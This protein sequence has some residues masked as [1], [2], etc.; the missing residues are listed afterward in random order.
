[1]KPIASILL[2]LAT[3]QICHAEEK[4]IRV[5]VALCDNA[6]QGIV[7]VPQRIGNG[8]QPDANLYWGCTEGLK[9][10]FRASRQWKLEK[11][12]IPRDQVVLERLEF[13]H[14]SGDATLVAE[15]YRGSNIRDCLVAFEKSVESDQYHLVAYIGHNGLMDF[16]LPQPGKMKR[17]KSDSV[18]LCCK[19]ETFFRRRLEKLGARPVLLTTQLMYPGSFILHDVIEKWL[20]GANREQLRIAAA[21][22][23]ARNQRLSLKAATGVFAEL[24]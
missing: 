13:K 14:V 5:F 11:R 12:E 10:F 15:A 7:P 2:V 17:G 1:M 23:Y 21:R 6:S 20:D 4:S 3:I 18:V 9:A 22:S 8:D 24:P 16:E 19:S